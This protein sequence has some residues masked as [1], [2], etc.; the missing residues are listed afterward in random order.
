MYLLI[1]K[2]ILALHPPLIIASAYLVSPFLSSFG[3]VMCTSKKSAAVEPAWMK[4][5]EMKKATP[6]RVKAGI[7]QRRNPKEFQFLKHKK[8]CLKCESRKKLPKIEQRR[9]VP[10]ATS[11]SLQR[12]PKVFIGIFAGRKVGYLIVY[13]HSVSNIFHHPNALF[14]SVPIDIVLSPSFVAISPRYATAEI[15][16]PSAF[17][18]FL[19]W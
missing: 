9:H 12:K 18:G 4:C 1:H 8:P 11:T 19:L 6:P 17:M 14:I 5:V 15:D 16:R 10:E 7:Y 2:Y 3:V 13:A